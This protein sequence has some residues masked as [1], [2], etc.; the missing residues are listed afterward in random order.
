MSITW[1]KNSFDVPIPYDNN[2]A[3]SST[4]DPIREAQ[5]WWSIN[6]ANA[7]WCDKLI[8]IG[9]GG[10]FHLSLLESNKLFG[11][12]EFR[13]NFTSEYRVANQLGTIYKWRSQI[14]SEPHLRWGIFKFKPAWQNYTLIYSETQDILNGETPTS[15]FFSK[16]SNELFV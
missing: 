14:E 15:K 16:L 1:I 4:Q 7:E 2:Y 12:V 5:Q 10:G 8:I 6:K 13:D 3:L 9:G 11:V